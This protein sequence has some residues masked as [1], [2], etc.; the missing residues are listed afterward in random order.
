M[1]ARQKA[2]PKLTQADQID[3]G[4]LA[5]LGLKTQILPPS[6]PIHTCNPQL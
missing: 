6:I 5:N 1:L 4:V 2:D 3:A